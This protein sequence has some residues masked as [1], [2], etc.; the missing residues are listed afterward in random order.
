MAKPKASTE[1]AAQPNDQR[2]RKLGVRSASAVVFVATVLAAFIAGPW[3]AL[4]LFG[5]F[6]AI[7]CDE[8]YRLLQATGQTKPLPLL[9]IFSGLTMYVL[10]AFVAS[11]VLPP[12]ALIWLALPVVVLF[13]GQLF[14]SRHM[15]FVDAGSTL[16]GALYVAGGFSFVP[17]MMFQ[18]GSYDYT[19]PLGVI[20]LVWANDTFAYLAGQFLGR[21]KMAVHISPNKTWEGF[22]GGMAFAVGAGWCIGQFWDVISPERWMVCGLL[23]A[24]FATLGDFLESQFK[25]QAGVKDSGNLMPGHGGVLDRFDGFLFAL[26]AVFLYVTRISA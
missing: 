26:P 1:A 6:T 5:V 12:T 4:G 3:T 8:A 21:T 16:S 9:G 19:L 13:V 15:A 25:R 24:V 18:S 14:V 22:V 17:L 20:F 2:L 7:G 10:A 11:D 23:T